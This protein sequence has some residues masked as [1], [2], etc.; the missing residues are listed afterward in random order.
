MRIGFILSWGLQL[1]QV[2]KNDLTG[3]QSGHFFSWAPPAIVQ[4]PA[5]QSDKEDES[6]SDPGRKVIPKVCSCISR[7]FM[8]IP[9]FP[10]SG[11]MAFLGGMFGRSQ[12]R[13]PLKSTNPTSPCYLGLDESHRVEISNRTY[14]WIEHL[15]TPKESMTFFESQN[16]PTNELIQLIHPNAGSAIPRSTNN[17]WGFNV[18]SCWGKQFRQL[19]WHISIPKPVWFNILWATKEMTDVVFKIPNDTWSWSS[20][21][22]LG[23][24]SIYIWETCSELT[25]IFGSGLTTKS[26]LVW[27]LW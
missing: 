12:K 10:W 4:E 13:Y 5:G 19:M 11:H 26:K 3:F 9:Q 17:S 24:C 25:Y 18:G 2:K 14:L 16:A 7:F 8:L 21:F 22:L 27:V 1:M 6:E 15:F 20:T 23:N